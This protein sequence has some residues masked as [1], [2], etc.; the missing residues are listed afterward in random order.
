MKV[1]KWTL[2]DVQCKTT[3]LQVILQVSL[4]LGDIRVALSAKPREDNYVLSAY[5][6]AGTNIV[7]GGIQPTTTSVQCSAS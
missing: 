6:K 4:R 1:L 7:P 5:V 2:D 3:Y